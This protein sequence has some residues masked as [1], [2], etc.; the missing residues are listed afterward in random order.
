MHRLRLDT[1]IFQIHEQFSIQTDESDCLNFMVNSLESGRLFK[2]FVF[3]FPREI[4]M[5]HI[6][7]RNYFTASQNSLLR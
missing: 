6:V 4:R 7:K 5:K 3:H 2:L 1:N